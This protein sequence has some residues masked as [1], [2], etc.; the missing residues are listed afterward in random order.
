MRHIAKNC[1]AIRE[2]YKKRNKRHHAYTV[3]YEEP[4]TK[5]I[6]E[7]IEDYVL[8]SALSG[9]MSPGEDTCLI[10][11]GAS[12][13][14]TG[15]RDILSCLTEKNFP[16]KITLGDDYQY[17]IKGVGESNYKLDSRTPM[18]MKDVLFVPS[19]TKNLCYI[20]ALDKKGFRFA[21]IDGEV[22]MYPKGKTMEEAIVIGKEEGGMYKLKGHS[23]EALT[24]SI[25]NPCELW[26][27]RL[28]HINYKALPCVSKAIKGLREFKVDHEGVCNGCA[29]GKNIKNPFPKRDSKA[30]GV[31]ELI[32]SDVCGPM[33]STSINGY[34]YYVSFIDDYSRKT[35]VYFLK[36]KDEVFGK[37]KEFKALIENLS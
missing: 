24:H 30:E 11:S 33:P 13:H 23:E 21:F 4:P 19:L 7:Q 5:M 22:L 14:M 15:Q 10:D 29:Q 8:I 6:K 32:H 31:L 16:Q 20:S 27:R 2:E 17:P 25:E 18:K 35:W 12:K 1:P 36:S 3:E 34:V 37:F 26:H 28:A 9:L